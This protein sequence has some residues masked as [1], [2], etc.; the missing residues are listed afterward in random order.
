M[1]RFID[2]DVLLICDDVVDGLRAMREG[3]VQM[4]VTSPPYFNLRLYGVEGEIG[5]EESVEAYVCKMVEIGREVR[6]VLREDGLFFLNLGDSYASGGSKGQGGSGASS[7]KQITN[8]GAYFSKSKRIPRGEGRW[9]GGNATSSGFK[10][11]DLMMIPARVALA[12]HADGWYLRNE[13]VWAKPNPM[14]NPVKDR[15]ATSHEMIYV[16]TKSSRNYFDWEAV[17]TE[18]KQVTLDRLL[19]GVSANHKNVNGAP[20]QTKHTMHQQRENVNKQDGADNNAYTGFNGRYQAVK[21]VRCRDVW[22]MAPAQ[23]KGSHYATYPIALPEKCILAGSKPGDVVLDPF[24][25]SGTTAI[26][27]V[28]HGRKFI[29]IDL[30]KRNVELAWQ[31]VAEERERLANP[32]PAKRQSKKKRYINAVGE[33]QLVL[34]GS[35]R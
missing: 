8:K 25:G 14:P 7:K 10:P 21:K 23:Y 15:F 17:A 22:T 34:P 27:C 20:G 13:V 31:R 32:K 29:G 12:L 9:G 28:R 19:P 33:E 26:A 5:Q 1:E 6:R 4:C 11:K 35:G 30:D 24:Y 3:S 16:F 2:D 18:P